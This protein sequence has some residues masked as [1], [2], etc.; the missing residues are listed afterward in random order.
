MDPL[1]D[2]VYVKVSNVRGERLVAICDEELLGKKVHDK[3]R[4]LTIHVNEYFYKGERMNATEAVDLLKSA[5]IANL[6]G[7]KIV[8]HAI[9]AG[10]IKQDAVAVIAGV[11][12]AQIVRM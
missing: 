1:K 10:F 7:K 8:Q 4:D 2:S 11:P 12:H 5:T 3:K 6:T 9:K